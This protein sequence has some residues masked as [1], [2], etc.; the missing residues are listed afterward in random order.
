MCLQLINLKNELNI[1]KILHME[2]DR[3]DLSNV[4]VVILKISLNSTHVIIL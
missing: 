1:G 3:K 4:E 2:E